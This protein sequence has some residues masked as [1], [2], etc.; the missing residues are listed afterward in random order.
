MPRS[1]ILAGCALMLSLTGCPDDEPGTDTM[2]QASGFAEDSTSGTEPTGTSGTG[3]PDTGE[4]WAGTAFSGELRG[5]LTF[6]FTPAHALHGDDV[7]GMAGGYRMAEIGWDGAEDL[8]SPV[9]YQLALPAPPDDADTVVPAEP[10]PV[11]DW[12]MVDDW[13]QA[14]NGM[15]LRQGEGGP[16]VLA[17]LLTTGGYPLYRTSDAMGVPAECNPGAAAWSAST[18]YDVVLYGGELFEDNVLLERVTTPP[19]LVVTAPDLTAF[20]AG[21]PGD[22]DLAIAWEAGDDPEARIII[23]VIDDNNNVITAHAAD[24]GSFTIPAAE[25]GALVAG[26]VDLSIA[27]ERTDRVQFTDGGLTVLSRYERWGFFDLY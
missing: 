25:L 24:D 5:V 26:P 14:G 12:G 21:V 18:A 11:Y 3:D 1:S 23:R 10:V 16:E 15:K 4:P 20:N 6:T 2:Q 17:C 22:Q 19:A 13:E 9:A 7:V 8:Y 27:R